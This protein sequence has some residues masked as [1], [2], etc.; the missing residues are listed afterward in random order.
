MKH[1]RT[2]QLALRLDASA[3]DASAAWGEGSRIAYLGGMLT[4][5]VASCEH[6]ARLDG[7]TLHLPLPPQPAGRQVQDAAEAWLR[8][9]AR[10]HLGNVVAEK[11]ALAGRRP[12]RLALSFAARGHWA[13]AQDATTLRCNWRLIEQPPAVIAQVIDRALAALPPAD[14]EADLFAALAG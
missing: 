6:H 14:A 2:P 9:A 12:P 1:T 4:L 5:R 3:P 13:E 10:R 7:A 11:S 8:D